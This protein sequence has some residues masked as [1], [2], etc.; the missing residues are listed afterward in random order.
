MATGGAAGAVHGQVP[1]GVMWLR[2][3]SGVSPSS[4]VPSA[5]QVLSLLNQDGV[6]CSLQKAR[7]GGVPPVGHSARPPPHAQPLWE[8][9][10]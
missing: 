5:G 4:S 10:L 3:W 2:K 7:C 8:G 9:R 1:K 6:T